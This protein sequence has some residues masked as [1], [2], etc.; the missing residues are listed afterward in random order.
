MVKS[1]L[2]RQDGLAGHTT[3]IYLLIYDRF[4]P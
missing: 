1:G 2:V 3:L 4:T